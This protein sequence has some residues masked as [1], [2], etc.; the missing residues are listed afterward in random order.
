MCWLINAIPTQDNEKSP[1]LFPPAGKVKGVTFWSPSKCSGTAK[2]IWGFRS[3]ICV[4]SYQEYLLKAP[5]W[6]RD[7][8]SRLISNFVLHF[9]VHSGWKTDDGA[10]WGTEER[11]EWCSHQNVWTS[12]T[13][14]LQV[15]CECDTCEVLF[16]RTVQFSNC[17]FFFFFF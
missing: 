4:Y 6:K 7:S 14:E 12:E 1:L 11:E 16:W 8:M 17:K 10:N 9:C 3:F 15:K 5:W 13:G 2:Q